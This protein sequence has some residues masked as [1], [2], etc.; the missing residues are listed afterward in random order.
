M[1]SDLASIDL[2]ST[3]ALALLIGVTLRLGFL[4]RRTHD[5]VRRQ[6]ALLRRAEWLD[7]W[8]R[9]AAEMT[10]L[11]AT[12]PYFQALAYAAQLAPTL[13][14]FAA[15]CEQLADYTGA[16]AGLRSAARAYADE[17]KAPRLPWEVWIEDTGKPPHAP[18]AIARAYR[19]AIA[20]G[21]ASPP[22]DPGN[23]R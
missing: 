18:T 17:L 2:M 13:E 9:N 22:P 15:D 10:P 20:S 8:V 3:L 21:R 16:P 14:Q 23:A 6:R 11:D 7:W 5:I 4:L 1:V 12:R 19:E